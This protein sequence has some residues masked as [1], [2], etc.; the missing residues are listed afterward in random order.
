[1]TDTLSFTPRFPCRWL[2]EAQTALQSSSE[3]VQYHALTLLYQLKQHDR[4]GVQKLVTQLSKAGSLIRYT[5]KLMHDEARETAGG[6]ADGSSELARAG[7]S[8]LEGSLRHRNELVIYEAA[9]AICKLPGVEPQDLAPGIT[10][11]QLFLSSPRPTVRYAAIKTLSEVAVV[12]PMAVVK[13]NDDMEM[14]ISDPNRSI[15]TLAIT[16]LLKTGSEQAV[17]RLMKQISNFMSDIGDEFKI[18]VVDSIKALC[19]KYPAKQRVLIG[20][21][22]NILREEGGESMGGAKRRAERVRV[23]EIQR[24]LVANTALMSQTPPTSRLT[25]LVAHRRLRTQED[26]RR[27]HRFPHGRHPGDEGGES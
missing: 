1:M 23:L 19:I 16:T 7:Y 21:L 12:A 24:S 20:F 26:H 2:N 5:S 3:M 10:V 15:A 18:I 22:S 25:S 8:F 27:L 11:L 9:R 14:L 6:V 13:I 17:D 4:L